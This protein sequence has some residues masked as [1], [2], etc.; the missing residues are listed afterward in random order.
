[1]LKRQQQ[2]RLGGLNEASPRPH[3]QMSHQKLYTLASAGSDLDRDRSQQCP[4]PWLLAGSKTQEC[5]GRLQHES[6]VRSMNQ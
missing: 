3:H 2:S 4:Q 6:L 1:M 5:F